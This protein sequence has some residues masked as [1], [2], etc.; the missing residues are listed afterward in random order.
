MTRYHVDSAEVAQ[1]AAAAQQS[2]SG[3]RAEVATL[4]G[5]LSSLEG[6]WQGTASTAFSGALDQWRSAQAQVETALE[7]LSQALNQAASTYQDAEDAT[8]RLFG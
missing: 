2:G 3:I 4:V 5:R 6:S 7:S 8:T 1:A